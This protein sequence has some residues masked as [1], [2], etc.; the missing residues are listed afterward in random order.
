MRCLA[1]C[2][3]CRRRIGRHPREKMNSSIAEVA[4]TKA[5]PKAAVGA[6]YKELIASSMV[7]RPLGARRFG[8]PAIEAYLAGPLARPGERRGH[9][10]LCRWRY[11]R[12][13]PFHRPTDG[14]PDKRSK[15][16]TPRQARFLP[17]RRA[18]SQLCC[19]RRR[20]FGDIHPKLH[21]RSLFRRV[22]RR[23]IAKSSSQHLSSRERAWS[24]VLAAPRQPTSGCLKTPISRLI[25]AVALRLAAENFSMNER[26]A[27]NASCEIG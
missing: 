8:P 22:A 9:A 26:K 21:I 15:R 7:D 12:A 1:L 13:V 23:E 14:R 25:P 6:P 20:S 17:F 5:V 19:C 3:S 11:P 18:R 24:P 27:E 16:A 10:A 2:P 4:R